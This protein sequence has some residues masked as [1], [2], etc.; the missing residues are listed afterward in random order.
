M[1]SMDLNGGVIV[2]RGSVQISLTPQ[3][4]E[5]IKATRPPYARSHLQRHLKLAEP[6]NEGQDG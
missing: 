4:V 1:I 6:E 2:T 3:E 5:E